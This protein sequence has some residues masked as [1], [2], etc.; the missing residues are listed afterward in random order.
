MEK[1]LWLIA[2]VR[3]GLQNFLVL[4]TFFW[5]VILCCGAVLCIGRCLAAPLAS[6]HSQP[7]VGDCDILKISKS[8]VEN[9]LHQL[10]YVNHF[11]VWVLHKLS[12]K[13]LY[14]I[15]ACDSLLKCNKNVP[16]LKQIV[17]GDEKWVL[18][19]NVKQKI[20]WGKRNEAPPTSSKLSLHPMKVLLCTWWD[21]KGV[22]YYELLLEN[23]MMNSN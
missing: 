10:G 5:S 11:N 22:L 13:N 3:S 17:T 14:H 21:W 15:S 19:N 1:V 4:L 18:Y 2:C 7:I 6:P 20:A 12:K 9:H 16:F 23:Q 8:S